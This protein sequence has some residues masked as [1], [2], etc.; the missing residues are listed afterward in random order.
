M[1]YCPR[2]EVGAYLSSA[3]YNHVEYFGDYD[4]AKPIGSAD[5]LVAVARLERRVD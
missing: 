5:R 4:T 3:G 2:E 1:R